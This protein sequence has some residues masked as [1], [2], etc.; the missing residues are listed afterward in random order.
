MT[1]LPPFAPRLDERLSAEFLAH[2]L[3]LLPFSFR[4]DRAILSALALRF[5]KPEPPRDPDLPLLPK[6]VYPRPEASLV[7]ATVRAMVPPPPVEGFTGRKAELDQAVLSIMAC[8]PPLITGES[9]AGKTALLRQIAADPRI[10]KAFK[11][12]WWLDDMDDAG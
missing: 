6:K 2:T 9:G 11:H 5:E 8:R 7:E 10:R 12:V 3:A 4:Q 1:S